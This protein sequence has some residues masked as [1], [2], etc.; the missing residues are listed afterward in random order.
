MTAGVMFLVS[1]LAATTQPHILFVL[2][3]DLGNDDIG[4]HNPTVKSITQNITRLANEGI[5][6]T[7]HLVHFHCS[8]TRRSFLSGRLPIHH[9]EELS[10]VA[11]DNL[12][13]RWSLVSDKLKANGYSTHW[14]GKGHVG[15]ESMNHLP[16]HRGFDSFLGF[17][18]GAQ[19]YTSNDRWEDE[20]PYNGTTYSSTLFGDRAVEII[21]NHALAYAALL[22]SNQTAL[23]ASSSTTTTP[24]FLYL[25]W[26]A[27]HSPYNPVPFWPHSDAEKCH[28]I[29]D[30]ETYA[31]MIWAADV[32]IGRIRIALETAKMYDSTLIVYTSD[33]GGVS[34]GDLDGVNWPLRGEKHSNWRGGYR[35]ATFVSGGF[36]PAK[37]RGTQSNLRVHI[38]DWYITFCRL[39]GGATEKCR[40]APAVKPQPIDPALGPDQDIYGNVSYPDVDGVDVW[41][42]VL[43]SAANS[44]DPFAAHPVLCVSAQVLLDGPLKL[45]VGQ[46]LVSDGG[47][48]TPGKNGWRLRNGSWIPLQPS[49]TCGLNYDPLKPNI[50][51]LFN[52]SDL[53]EH[54]DLS[55][56]TQVLSAHASLEDGPA[57]VT[58]MWRLLN[59]TYLPTRFMSRS[60]AKLLGPCNPDCAEKVWKEMGGSGGGPTCGVP[61]CGT[62]P[63]G[64][65]PG[66]GPSPSP[67]NNMCKENFWQRGKC[68]TNDAAHTILVKEINS[69]PAGDC[70]RC[71]TFCR[72]LS[73][74]I[75]FFFFFFFCF[76]VL[77]CALTHS[78]TTVTRVY[79]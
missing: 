30:N 15:F 75:I 52:E 31:G 49:W 62:A 68:M 24:L 47:S 74:L 38:V 13:L 69:G 63:P 25:P 7:Q 40:D 19:S 10:Q 59:E 44:V 54:T 76:F 55:K 1:T 41:S 67:R 70:C 4:F 66:P 56:S 3:D 50:P 18:G 32:Q 16:T 45:L 20:G 61:G 5:E 12:D 72:R 77:L 53:G 8:P 78:L 60:P 65:A 48:K 34:H 71:V 29:A 57:S 79:Q 46:S 42:L 73:C 9:G 11:S 51:C 6:L 21:Q 43:N 27:V 2:Q 64:P 22:A 26:Q 14:V 35:T 33:N 28:C 17:L 39:A 23:A 36:I 58:R 37:L